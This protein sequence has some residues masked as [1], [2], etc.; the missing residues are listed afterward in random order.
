MLIKKYWE[1]KKN[2]YY[3]KTN[4]NNESVNANLS[5]YNAKNT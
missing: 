5:K 4:G 3:T 1:E 2:R